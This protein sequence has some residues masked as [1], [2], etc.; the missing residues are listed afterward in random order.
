VTRAWLACVLGLCACTVT[1]TNLV[2]DLDAATDAKASGRAPEAELGSPAQAPDAG[3]AAADAGHVPSARCGKAPCA[4]DDGIDNDGDGLIDGFDPE[5]TGSFDNDEGSF[6]IGKPQRH[7]NCRECYW[8]DAV[9]LGHGCRYPSECLRGQAPPSNG[10]CTSCSVS[11][12]CIDSCLDRTP[13]GCDCFGCCEIARADGSEVF[14]ELT[15]SCSLQKLDDEKACPRCVQNTQ[16]QN[17]CGR[18][19]LCL[20]R[21]KASQ[22]PADC[23]ASG[24]NAP[25]FTCDQGETV[26][27]SS[28]ECPGMRYCQLGCCLVDLI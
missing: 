23:A 5:C 6:G 19:E 22:L 10:A 18:C 9:G 7:G 28:A 2:S 13:N 16:C 3:L 15:D 17:P 8:D 25:A 12:S 27:A 4:C 14:I 1:R 24:G 11:Q 21:T 20:G 26:C